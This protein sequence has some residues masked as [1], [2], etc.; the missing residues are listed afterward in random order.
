MNTY[1][2]F[3]ARI[4]EVGSTEDW[5]EERKNVRFWERARLR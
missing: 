1:S 5:D 2:C 4:S 3:P